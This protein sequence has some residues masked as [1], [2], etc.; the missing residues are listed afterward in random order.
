MRTKA[1]L[2]AAGWAAL[3]LGQRPGMGADASAT[4]PAEVDRSAAILTPPSP[5]TPRINGPHVYG[6]RT[7]KPFFYA[8][9]ATGDRP[10]TFAADGLPEGLSI[11]AS[12]G[13]ITGRCSAAGHH[14]VKLTATNAKGTSSI[15]LNIVIGDQVCLTPP[16]GWNSWNKFAGSVDD[17]KVRAAADAMVSSGLINHGWTY[18]NIDDTWEIRPDSNDPRLGGPAR[19][20]QGRILTNKKFPDMKALSDYVHG[21]GLKFGIYSSPGPLTCA[22]YEATYQHEDQ[23]A[24]SYADW[25][26]DYVKYDWCSYGQIARQRTIALYA[27][28]LPADAAQLKALMPEVDKLG[29]RRNRTPDEEAQ[30][31]ALHAQLDPILAKLDPAKRK[32]LDLQVLQEPY[33]LFRKSLDKVDRDIIFSYCQYGMGNVWEWGAK[34]GG[35]TWRT[36][37]DIAARWKSISTIGFGQAGHEQYAGPSHWNDPDMLEVGNGKL[38]PDEMYTHMTLW[39]LLDAPLLIGCDMTQ[40]DALTTS[41]FSNDEVLAVNQDELGKQAA[42]I[43]QDGEKEIWAKPMADGTMAVGLFNRGEESADVAVSWSDLKLSGS[44]PVRDLWRQKDLGSQ[45]DGWSTKVNP[46]GAVLIRV[47][48]PSTQQ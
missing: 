22:R 33:V 44:Q 5:D 6:E 20:A 47:G 15:V 25:G 2:L 14:K 13:Y 21:K 42:R 41:L 18:I 16:L 19:D 29:S 36:T 28:A 3:V 37:G 40:M 26:V 11:D 9:P 45:A 39:C 27:E 35:N 17:A 48:S 30:L 32:Q 24:Q 31:K 23:D 38:T 34:A 12:T 46:H 8:V 1:L 7:G 10:I 4:Q 43:K